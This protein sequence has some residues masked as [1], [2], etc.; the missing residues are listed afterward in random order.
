MK[1]Y[2]TIILAA[3]LVSA[4]GSKE[5]SSSNT[6][7]AASI[8][9][10]SKV[11]SSQTAVSQPTGGAPVEFTYGGITADK[12]NI[13]YKIKV[14]TDKPI[15]EV[16]LA[17]KATDAGGKVLDQT[18]IAWQNIVK[19]TRQPI[20]KGK[21]YEDTSAIDPATAKVECSLKEVVFKDGTTWK[22]K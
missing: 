9:S 17:F 5:L 10:P 6:R 18:M 2:V 14:N 3:V 20:E 15:E 16:H 8:Q 7:P 13:S 19:S 4:C 22:A 1:T 12:A 11:E 21:T